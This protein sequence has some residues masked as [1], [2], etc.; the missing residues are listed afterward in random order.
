MELDYLRF[1]SNSESPNY[2][3]AVTQIRYTK[4]IHNGWTGEKRCKDCTGRQ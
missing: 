1:L 4:R 3:L 2:I